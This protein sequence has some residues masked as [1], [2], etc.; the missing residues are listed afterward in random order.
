MRL[1]GAQIPV[2]LVESWL[3]ESRAPAFWVEQVTPVYLSMHGFQNLRDSKCD[4]AC[5]DR[6]LTTTEAQEYAAAAHLR[7]EGRRIAFYGYALYVNKANPLDAVFTRHMRLV[8]QQQIKDWS[9][10]AGPELPNC[11]GPIHLFG[12]E[13]G[14][15]GGLV[16]A[17]LANVWFADATWTVCAS[18]AEI[19]ARVA[20]DPLA[21]GFASVGYDGDEV[22]YL[23]LREDRRG[24]PALPSLEAIE[25]EQY[26]LAK[27]IYLYFT[28]PASPAVQAVLEFLYSAAGQRTLQRSYVWPVAAE[29]A[30]VAA[31]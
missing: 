28:E 30:T 9:A 12:P 20:A 3:H 7:F 21:L 31:K 26:P 4:L 15:R 13:K 8:F 16:L 24:P 10:L 11:T 1:G 14:S 29:R 18:D 2:E 23:G 25:A 19:I 27:V 5:T 22:R 17:P 6:P